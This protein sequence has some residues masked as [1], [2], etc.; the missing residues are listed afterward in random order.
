MA[1]E[2]AELSGRERVA[3]IEAAQVAYERERGVSGSA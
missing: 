3:A 1:R 2:R